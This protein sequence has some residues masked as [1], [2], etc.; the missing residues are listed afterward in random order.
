MRVEGSVLSNLGSVKGLRL[1]SLGLSLGVEAILADLAGKVPGPAVRTAS[2]G[3]NLERP[4]VNPACRACQEDRLMSRPSPDEVQ[5][6]ILEQALRNRCP[7]RDSVTVRRPRRRVAV[8][9][10][11]ALAVGR[12][13]NWASED[14]LPVTPGPSDFAALGWRKALD[15]SRL[16]TR[17]CQHRSEIPSATATP[18]GICMMGGSRNS[19]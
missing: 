11:A 19:A 8:H 15:R 18:L 16:W 10:E 4:S 7:G 1:V 12:S 9:A 5:P 3:D 13:G 2:R 6:G 17:L 14:L